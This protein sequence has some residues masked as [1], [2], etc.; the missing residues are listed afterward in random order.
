MRLLSVVGASPGIGKSR[1]CAS[2][3]EWLS[4]SGWLVDHFEEDHV[5][6]RPAFAQVAADFTTTGRVDPAVLVDA[7]VRYVT[8]AAVAGVEVIV[9]DSLI[10]YVPSLIAL[11]YD[12]PQI[13]AI[14][15]GLAD[16]IAAFPTMAIFLDGDASTSLGRAAAREG[17]DWLGWY[18]AKLARYGVLAAPEP[19]LDALSDYLS[20]ERA[21]TLRVLRRQPWALSVVER[22]DE[23]SPED[24]FEVVRHAVTGFCGPAP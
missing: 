14:V 15:D 4:D 11:G 13:A 18:A 21:L 7:T 10:P 8:E 2:L 19:N 17:P 9:M 16:R 23:L 22:V 12:E 5:L 6:T 1:L 20:R 24:V 3:T